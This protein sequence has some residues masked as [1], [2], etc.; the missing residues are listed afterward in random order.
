MP[1]STGITTTMDENGRITLPQEIRQAA[2]VPPQT[3]LTV[4]VASDGSIVLKPVRD[5][6]Q[7]WFWTEEW[8]AGER[9]AD[10]QIAKGEGTI[11]EN[12]EEFSRALDEML[13]DA[14]L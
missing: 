9:E 8:Q 7:A 2:H 4:E 12:E 1:D 6:E 11:Y 14:D 10:E 13:E 5:P 3:E